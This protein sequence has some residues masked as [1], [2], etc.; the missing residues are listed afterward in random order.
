ML[1]E[2]ASESQGAGA[3]SVAEALTDCEVQSLRQEA[4]ENDA[5]FREAF[6]HLR[7]KAENS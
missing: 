1:R 7:P 3:F 5:Y 4:K 6:A 2:G